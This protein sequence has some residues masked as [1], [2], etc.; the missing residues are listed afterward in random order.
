MLD[1]EG[2]FEVSHVAIPCPFSVGE[3]HKSCGSIFCFCFHGIVAWRRGSAVKTGT[4]MERTDGR[5]T[6]WRCL[7]TLSPASCPN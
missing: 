3:K 1:P 2:L 7:A 6:G 4:N 5:V